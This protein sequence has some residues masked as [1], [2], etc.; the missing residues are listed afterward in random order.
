MKSPT[1]VVSGAVIAPSTWPRSTSSGGSFASSSISSGRDRRARRARRPRIASTCVV[2][3]GVAER[4]RDRDRVAVGL[5]ERDRGRALEQRE[6]R[7]RAGRLGRAPRQRVLDDGEPRAVLR[8]ARVRR[9][10]ICGHRQPAVVG[11]DQRLRRPAAARSARRRPVPSRFFMHPSPPPKSTRA[12]TEAGSERALKRPPRAASAGLLPLG[13]LPAVS[14]GR[15]RLARPYGLGWRPPP[16]SSTMPRVRAGS[17]LMPGPIVLGERDLPGCSGPSPPPASPAR[18]RRRARRSSRRA[19]R[20]SKLCL[21]IG[22]WTFAPRSVRY[23]SLPAFASRTAFADVQRHRARLRVR[24]QPARA[25]DAAELA[26]DA[27]L[28]GRRDRDVEVGR[29]PPRSASARSAAPTTSAPASSASFAFSPSAKTATRTS[30]PVPCGSISVPRSC[31]SAWRTLSP[32]WKC[33]STVSSNFA[34][35][36]LLQQ[37]GPPRPAS[38]AARGRSARARRGSACRASPSAP[39]PPRPSSARCRRRPSSPARRR[40]RS[41]PRASSRRSSAPGRCVRRPTLSRFGSAEPFS[42]L[43]ASLISTA[44]GGVFVMNVNE[45]SSKTVIST[46]RDAAVLLRGLRVERLAELHDVDAVLAERGADRRRRVRLPAGDLELDERQD[47]LR[48]A[49]SRSSSPGRSR[50]RR[51]PGARRCRRAP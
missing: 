42:R 31:W 15:A 7:V 26:D 43:S 25:E 14:G 48:H 16:S 51:E 23:S 9:S 4:L 32:R 45:R 2:A 11:D 10:S 24:H 30:L 41:G 1:T 18:S 35:A 50:A 47:F 29:S 20:S 44:A 38:R 49:V 19:R 36:K 5:E 46:G 6:Q 17:T 37:S 13:A 40:A 34:A 22:T 28:V 12:R 27:H 21:P 33:T 39:P 3:R 8:A